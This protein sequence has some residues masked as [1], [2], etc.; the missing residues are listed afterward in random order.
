[1]IDAR[2]WLPAGA[3]PDKAEAV[4]T[5]LVAEWS[6]HWFAGSEGARSSTL[7]RADQAGR[8]LRNM[9][10]HR[11]DAGTAVGIG[12]SGS[13]A[14]GARAMGVAA[15]IGDRTAADLALLRQLGEECLQ[16]LRKRLQALLELG[17]GMRWCET[18]QA[19]A[20]DEMI[21][22]SEFGTRSE[23]LH[24]AI[25][26]TPYQLTRL[27]RSCLPAVPALPPLA[28]AEEAL[29]RTE[30]RLSAMLAGCELTLA[31]IEALTPGDVLVLDH[32]VDQALPLAIE[33]RPAGRGACT[34]A[35]T[36]EHLGLQL[37]QALVG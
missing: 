26:L 21:V 25:A 9:T 18:P 34:V 31:E 17:S 15:D 6:N 16:D 12:A 23:T 32:R 35:G 11:C 30:L 4:M 1:M 7:A 28:T 33:Y 22:R 24:L 3:S 5:R 10:W 2:T 36:G 13:T 37:T 19:P 20:P 29:A 14:L 8:D 27:I